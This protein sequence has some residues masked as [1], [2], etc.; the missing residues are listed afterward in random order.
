MKGPVLGSVP[1]PHHVDVTPAPGKLNYAAQAPIICYYMLI[2]ENFN[3]LFICGSGASK[4][5][6]FIAAPSL[7]P[8]TL[9][10]KMLKGF[11]RFVFF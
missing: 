8:A 11:L 3:S 1:E 10:S 4:M 2:N 9:V 5:M 6:W 7:A